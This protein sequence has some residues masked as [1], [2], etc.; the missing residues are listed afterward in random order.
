M[1]IGRKI[2][3]GY[4]IILLIV[5][6]LTLVLTAITLRVSL[7]RVAISELKSQ[8]QAI[9]ELVSKQ[10]IGNEQWQNP[11]LFRRNMHMIDG[12]SDADIY[13][14][15]GNGN[16]IYRTSDSLTLQELKDI[17][18]QTSHV[19]SI[20]PVEGRDGETWAESYWSGKG[21]RIRPSSGQH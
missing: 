10:G 8:G 15:S 5:C 11:V 6:L 2:M 1:T 17:R 20:T 9:V 19:Y 14:L 18:E 13:I 12:V 16:L 4:A 3:S 7:R 21:N